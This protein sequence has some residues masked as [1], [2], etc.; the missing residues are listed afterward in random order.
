[1]QRRY[2]GGHLL[3]LAAAFVFAWNGRRHA[4]ARRWRVRGEPDRGKSVGLQEDVAAEAE[5]RP[6]T[7]RSTRLLSGTITTG[8]PFRAARPAYTSEGDFARPSR[9]QLLAAGPTRG[10]IETP[11]AE[12]AFRPF[13]NSHQGEC[14]HDRDRTIVGRAVERLKAA[15][16]IEAQEAYQEGREA[17]ETWAKEAATLR[18]LR[19]LDRLASNPRKSIDDHLRTFTDDRHGGIAESLYIE[20]EPNGTDLEGFWDEALGEHGL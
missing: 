5:K 7:G 4:L 13:F 14:I 16:K 20:I 10:M 6:R 9:E 15:V 1:M 8:G 3:V 19:R 11:G 2:E 12:C 18:Q 17:G